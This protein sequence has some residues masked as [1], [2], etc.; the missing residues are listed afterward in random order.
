MFAACRPFWPCFT[1]NST[2]WFS[3]S[4][5]NPL[6][7]MSRKWANRSAPP[8]S[9]AMKPKPLLSLNHFTVPVWVVIKHLSYLRNECAAHAAHAATLKKRSG[10]FQAARREDRGGRTRITNNHCLAYNCGA[11]VHDGRAGRRGDLMSPS[12][13]HADTGRWRH[14]GVR[15]IAADRL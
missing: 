3:A 4:V 15:V 6:P 11:N 1:S 7:W 13:D 12:S 14:D 10:G 8:A 9:C 2:R 5:L